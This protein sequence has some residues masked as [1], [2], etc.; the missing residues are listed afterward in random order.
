[1]DT[2]SRRFDSIIIAL[3]DR[4]A[5]LDAL[6]ERDLFGGCEQLVLPTSA[7][8]SWRLSA[9]P[10]DRVGARA[11]PA[12]GLLLGLGL[13]LHDLDRVGLELALQGLGVVVAEVV[14]DRERLELGRLDVATALFGPL[15]EG[16]QVLG[17]DQFVQLVLRQGDCLNPFV[18]FT[19]GVSNKL[20]QSMAAF[21]LFPGDHC[22]PEGVTKLQTCTP[23]SFIPFQTCRRFTAQPRM[24]GPRTILGA[25]RRGPLASYHLR[26][27][28]LRQVRFS[29]IRRTSW[30]VR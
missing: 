9:A 25:S 10:D 19:F 18:C 2:T 4:V 20:T 24:I 15:D 3:R 23:C 17:F 11:A 14:L 30:N 1:M 26:R 12:G 22:T 21:L 13:G 28:C 7:R 27:S 8:K 29:R 16:L 5:A 6:R